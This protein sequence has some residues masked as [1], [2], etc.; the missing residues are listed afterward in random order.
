MNTLLIRY[1]FSPMKRSHFFNTDI[2]YWYIYTGIKRILNRENVLKNELGKIIHL[3]L[4]RTVRPFF[5]SKPAFFFTTYRLIKFI[6]FS[7]QH[8]LICRE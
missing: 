1:I 3:I 2:V 4:I 6:N 5:R 7:G 8:V